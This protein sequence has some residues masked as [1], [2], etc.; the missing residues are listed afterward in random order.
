MS[1]FAFISRAAAGTVLVAAVGFAQQATI[2]SA[3]PE[4]GELV[5][6]AVAN[7][8]KA[9]TDDTARSMFRGTKTTPRGSVTKIYVETNEATA[10]LVVAYDGKPLAP[11]QRQA[12]EARIDRFVKD[13]EELRKKRR[14]EQQDAE[15][16]L[17]ILRAIP[18]AFIFE[19]AGE[20]A[21]SPGV[22]K[23]GDSLVALKFRPNPRYDPPSRIEQ[24]LT[25]MEGTLLVDAARSRLASVE[26]TLFKEVGFGWGI[27]GHLDKG[28]HY[29]VQQ[30]EIGDNHWAISRMNLTFTGKILLIRSLYLNTTDVFSDFKPVPEMT[31]AQAIELLK[32]EE[33]V[34]AENPTAGKMTSGKS[35]R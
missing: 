2:S 8:V 34:V 31:F 1:S 9:A 3:P 32:K 5:R 10:G 20:Q 33:P 15:R 22:G 30:Q 26:G 14:Q 18:V 12:E 19:Y 35:D 13:P 16:S 11:E 27:L 6:K 23:L 29:L 7:E 17:R 28:G 4:P 25:G 21:A 24:V